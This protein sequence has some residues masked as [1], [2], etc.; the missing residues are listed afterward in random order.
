[1]ADSRYPNMSYCM[2]ENTIA[3]MGQLLEH[4][5]EALDGGAPEV[6]D[7]ITSMSREEKR[8][9][10]E[11]FETCREYMDLAEELEDVL[12]NEPIPEETEE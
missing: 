9:F 12:E 7:F 11:M 1:M 10:N 3:A 5:R 6:H 8:A 4:M 2:F